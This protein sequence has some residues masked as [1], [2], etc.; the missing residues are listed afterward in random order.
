MKPQHRPHIALSALAA[1]VLL[2]A[3]PAGA[4]PPAGKRAIESP[5]LGQGPATPGLP[6]PVARLDQL[7]AQ[8]EAQDSTRPAALYAGP[9]LLW[10]GPARDMAAALASD[11][12]DSR[13]STE[14]AGINGRQR[15]YRGPTCVLLEGHIYMDEQGNLAIAPDQ[16]ICDRMR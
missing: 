8:L 6:S 2:S 3:A 10:S 11:A 5:S 13:P 9:R 7:A 12:S 14:V 16:I 15:D 4:D 1:L